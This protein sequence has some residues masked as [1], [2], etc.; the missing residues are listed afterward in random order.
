MI[1]RSPRTPVYSIYKRTKAGDCERDGNPLIYALKG[2]YGYSITL[3]ELFKFRT[4]F[5]SILSAI[6]TKLETNNKFVISVLSSSPVVSFLAKRVSRVFGASRVDVFDKCTVEDVIGR[7]QKRLSTVNIKHKDKSQVN[8]VLAK[9]SRSSPNAVF[10]MK[11]VPNKIRKYFQPLKLKPNINL[12]F[13]RGA[14]IILI[15]DLL[16]SGVTLVSASEELMGKNIQCSIA[17]CLLS[18]LH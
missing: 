9:L 6:N 5:L 4:S 14:E 12:N 17:V 11:N 15:D 8:E 7:F 3:K 16:S 2:I 13:L 10:S 1:G 18:D